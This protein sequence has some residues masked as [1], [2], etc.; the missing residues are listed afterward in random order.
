MTNARKQES[1][2]DQSNGE[3]FPDTSDTSS[4]GALSSSGIESSS[5][6]SGSVSGENGTVRAGAGLTERLA[7]ILVDD[8]DGDLLLQQSDREDRVLQ[9]LQALDMQVM[10]ACRVDE[11]L[12]PLLKVN[13]SSGV[14]ED[15][16]LAHLSQH[17]DPSEVGMLARCFC[18][19]LVSIRVGKVSKQGTL[20]CPTTTRGNLSLM[21]LPTSDLRLSFIGDDGQ[22]ERLFTLS[23]KSQ[24]A[25]VAITDIPADNS[26][27]SF[28]VKVPDGKMFYYWCSE[29]SKLL[30]T[31]LLSKMKGL[32]KR[33][34]SIAELTGISESRL[35]CFA[36][37]LRA[38]LV[39]T[40][41]SITQASLSGSPLSSPETASDSA[42]VQAAQ[43]SSISKSLRSQQSSSQALKANSLSPRTSSFKEGPFRNLSSLRSAARDKLLK[44]GE[45]HLSVSDNVTISSPSTTDSCSS[46]QAENNKLPDVKSCP[47][48]PDILESLGKFALPPSLGPTSQLSSIGPPLFSPYYCWCP[49]GSSSLQHSTALPEFPASSVNSF[50]LPPLSSILPV[51][52]TS[53][54][55][56]PTPSI[57]LAHASSLDFPALLPDPLVHLPTANS[58]QIPTFTPLMCD[59]IVHIPVI[60]VCS[61]GQ[62]YLVVSAGPAISTTIPPLH[63]KL[64]NPLLPETD[65]VVESGARETLRLLISSSSQTTPPLLDVL[66][67]VLTNA[68]DKRSIF[69][70]GSRALYSGTRDV[71]GIV[72]GIAAMSLVTL[73][74]GT[75]GTNLIKKCNSHDDLGVQPGE[76][77]GSDGSSS[78][79]EATHP[80]NLSEGSSNC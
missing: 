40:T 11:R 75:M 43:S 46:N 33:K 41:V 60:D 73:S 22:T 78:D 44:H 14:T 71:N 69:V 37:L 72:D 36:T 17:F 62:G 27:R 38:Y 56:K 50:P 1:V 24:C 76:S 45:S 53:S 48:A 8:G 51:N 64:V 63:P 67:A 39:G 10:G 4:V 55:L 7:D 30:G 32:I 26:G 68:D 47:L 16:L 3:D 20:L 58:E 19:P 12:K 35:G 59:P 18:I 29:K 79:S 70:A 77:A 61:S 52:S 2:D 13:V 31:E 21:L 74:G 23:S 5:V 15:R 34:P 49:P 28:H 80:S 66:P 57:N 25:A 54:F 42:D 6:G 65:A 9:W